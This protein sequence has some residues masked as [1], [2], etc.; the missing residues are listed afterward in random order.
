MRGE[1]F[2]S[3]EFL[4]LLV[5]PRA[6]VVHVLPFL[7]TV[8]DS[9]GSFRPLEQVFRDPEDTSLTHSECLPHVFFGRNYLRNSIF[10]RAAIDGLIT[11]LI[12]FEPSWLFPLVFGLVPRHLS[13]VGKTKQLLEEHQLSSKPW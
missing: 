11:C 13:G 9:I 2:C 5:L 6:V 1:I 10:R 3:K 8:R 7:K 12:S 4:G